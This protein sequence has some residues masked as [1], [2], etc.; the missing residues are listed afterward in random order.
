MSKDESTLNDGFD[1]N[2]RSTDNSS[3]ATNTPEEFVVDRERLNKS[4]FHG[5][6]SGKYGKVPNEPKISE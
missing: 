2:K 4:E 1:N 6:N 3:E 5:T